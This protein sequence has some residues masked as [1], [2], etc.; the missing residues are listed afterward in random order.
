[1]KHLS[2]VK[3]TKKLSLINTLMLKF[4]LNASTL[5]KKPG[6]TEEKKDIYKTATLYL[7][8]DD[9][10][11]YLIISTCYGQSKGREPITEQVRIG[12]VF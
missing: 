12:F 2:S 7:K 5:R 8:K 4:K 6:R 11:S 1:M 10:I 9:S 3:S